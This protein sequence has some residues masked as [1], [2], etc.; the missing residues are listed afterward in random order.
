VKVVL[1]CIILFH[2]LGDDQSIPTFFLFFINPFPNFQRYAKKKHVQHV[3]KVFF[4]L[5]CLIN[6][7]YVLVNRTA[8]SWKKVWL[9]ISCTNNY[10]LF[11]LKFQSTNHR[12]LLWGDPI[13]II[14]CFFLCTLNCI[15]LNLLVF[16]QLCNHIKLRLVNFTRNYGKRNIYNNPD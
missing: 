2:L 12:Y 7:G 3:M 8:N 1:F 10:L 11:A 15:I 5:I 16:R 9:I 4:S 14:C 13:L 6:S